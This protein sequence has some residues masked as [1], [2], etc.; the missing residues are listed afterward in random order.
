MHMKPMYLSASYWHTHVSFGRAGGR[1]GGSSTAVRCGVSSFSARHGGW[2][3]VSPRDEHFSFSPM[4]CFSGRKKAE[5]E[6]DNAD[7]PFPRGRD[8]IWPSSFPLLLPHAPPWPH[9]G[10]VGAFSRRRPCRREAP[11]VGL[12]TAAAAR[13]HEVSLAS[14]ELPTAGSDGRT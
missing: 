3:V 8:R 6:S 4:L 1:Q 12:P 2:S 10:R 9:S 13:P 7:M 14:H 5:E 11:A